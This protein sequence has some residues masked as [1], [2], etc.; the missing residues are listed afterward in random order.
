MEKDGTV[1]YVATE[2]PPPAVF[3][4]MTIDRPSSV[5]L[6]A[7]VSVTVLVVRLV[8]TIYRTVSVLVIAYQIFPGNRSLAP[9]AQRILVYIS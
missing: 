6:I 5:A 7:S 1:R 9:D 8:S 2:R 4:T 3:L